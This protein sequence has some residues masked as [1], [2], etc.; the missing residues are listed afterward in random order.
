[1][2]L[3]K[4]YTGHSGTLREGGLEELR[5][6]GVSL[7]PARL[8]PP[9]SEEER[10][11]ATHL[12]CGFDLGMTLPGWT[13]GTVVWFQGNRRGA[14]GAGGVELGPNE[15]GTAPGGFWTALSDDLK[16][17][18][19][20]DRQ[21]YFPDDDGDEFCDYHVQIDDRSIACV[22]VRVNF[23]VGGK[24]MRHAFHLSLENTQNVWLD[25]TDSRNGFFRIGRP[26]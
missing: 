9:A 25:P 19:R 26:R 8:V 20:I 12:I 15:L 10:E 2:P 11:A 7:E 6:L 16:Q 13:C 1:M 24:A 3:R 5:G 17:T 22:L 18:A 14:R 21:K 4:S 23:D